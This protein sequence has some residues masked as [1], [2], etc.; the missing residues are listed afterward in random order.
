MPSPRHSIATQR[1]SA[2]L[3]RICEGGGGGGGGGQFGLWP[4][5]G[6]AAFVAAKHFATAKVPFDAA[7]A[8]FA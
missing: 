2:S 6:E 1:L 7:K 8:R 4:R 5:R 3:R